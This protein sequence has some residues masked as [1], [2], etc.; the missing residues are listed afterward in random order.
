MGNSTINARNCSIT[1]AWM[2]FARA[3]AYEC[4]GL[5]CLRG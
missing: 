3:C 5:G 2:F 4:K 1:N